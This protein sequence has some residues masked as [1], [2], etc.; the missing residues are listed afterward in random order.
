[1]EPASHRS[2]KA[3]GSTASLS[4]LGASGMHILLNLYSRCIW[5]AYP[6]QS[7]FSI[8]VGGIWATPSYMRS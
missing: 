4:S 6:A 7:L 5:D 2:D 1:M 8:L 3:Q